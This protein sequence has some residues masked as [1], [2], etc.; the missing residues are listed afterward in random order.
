MSSGGAGARFL[1][2]TCLKRERKNMSAYTAT[3]NKFCYLNYYIF[4]VYIKVLSKLLLSCNT[5]LF[6]R[7]YIL[8]SELI[9]IDSLLAACRIILLNFQKRLFLIHRRWSKCARQPHLLTWSQTFY[10]Q[11]N[12]IHSKAPKTPRPKPILKRYTPWVHIE[13]YELWVMMWKSKINCPEHLSNTRRS[14]TKR[15]SF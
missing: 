10:Y 13:R 15:S 12:G 7:S 3:V 11:N 9:Y 8:A 5:K 1:F 4:N 14:T 6:I 2:L